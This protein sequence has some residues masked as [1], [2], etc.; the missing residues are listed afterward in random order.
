MSYPKPFGE[1]P[2]ATGEEDVYAPGI[3]VGVVRLGD[4][5]SGHG[6]Y[7]PRPNDQASSNVFVNNIA[8]HRETDS[9]ALHCN[10]DCHT[11]VLSAGS[12]SVFV[13]NLPI[14]RIGDPIS[15]GST[16]AQGSSNVF[17]GG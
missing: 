4:M 16:A 14:A 10:G 1:L 3:S 2:Y 13:N 5:C 11:G 15:C 12:S 17:A 8:A 7:P 9:W 6:P